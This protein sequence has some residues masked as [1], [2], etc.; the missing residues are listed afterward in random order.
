MKRFG[1]TQAFSDQKLD[2]SQ[3]TFSRQSD[4]TAR[5]QQN[6][7]IMRIVC[8]RMHIRASPHRYQMDGRSESLKQD[9]ETGGLGDNSESLRL[10]VDWVGP[11]LVCLNF[12]C[13]SRSHDK[14]DGACC[15][16]LLLD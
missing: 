2:A 1:E 5:P 7:K 15:E 4:S 10:A 3:K 14:S 9:L 13:T 8:Q 11:G 16:A 12:P 6:E